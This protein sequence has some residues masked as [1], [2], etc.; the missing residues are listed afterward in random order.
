MERWC[1]SGNE[2]ATELLVSPGFILGLSLLLLNDFV[3]KRYFHGLVTGKLSDFAGLF[4]FPLFWVALSPRLRGIAYGL[5]AAIFVFW[6]SSYSQPLIDTWNTV[7]LFSVSRSVDYGDLVALTVLP[8]S[9]RYSLNRSHT[10]SRN[11]IY[12]IGVASI[13]AFTATSYSSKTPYDTRYDFQVS[14]RELLERMRQLSSEDV[15]N[16]FWDADDFEV[17]F[18]DCVG[19]AKIAV[20]ETEKHAVL[21]LKEINYRCPTPPGKDKMQKFFEQEFIGKLNEPTVTKSAKVSYIW[22]IPK[23]PTPTPSPTKTKSK[24]Q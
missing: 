5:T 1:R 10:R 7:C 9:Y 22:G 4:V 13:L 11:W 8:W 18:D 17:T 21:T 19:N 3:F 20:N 12:A 24:N 14:K 15:R 23:E 6:K 2:L 16:T